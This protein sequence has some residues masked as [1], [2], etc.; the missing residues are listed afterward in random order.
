MPNK[1]LAPGSLWIICVLVVGLGALMTMPACGCSAR[2]RAT[3]TPA[4]TATSTLT[5]SATWTRGVTQTPEKVEGATQ[6]LTLTTPPVPTTASTRASTQ[7][8]ASMPLATPTDAVPSTPTPVPTVTPTSVPTPI[9]CNDLSAL[10]EMDIAPGQPFE[11][12]THQDTITEELR[13]VPEVPCG[14]VSILF[15]GGQ[16]SFICEGRLTVTVTGTIAAQECQIDVQITGGTPGVGG[17]MQILID[18]L[19]NYFPYDKLCFERADLADGELIV[20]GYGR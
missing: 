14:D 3:S 13:S 8:P 4:A 10:T 19:L 6:A 2:D 12:T 16:F 5:P 20:G 9:V 17:A 18:T 15:D 7:T 11:C 1:R